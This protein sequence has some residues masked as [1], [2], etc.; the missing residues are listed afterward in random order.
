MGKWR[1][2]FPAHKS[3]TKWI[4][5][6]QLHAPSLLPPGKETPY[7][8]N[9]RLSGPRSLFW[10]LNQDPSGVLFVAE[11]LFQMGQ[12]SSR[13]HS[14]LSVYQEWGGTTF[15]ATQNISFSDRLECRN[16]FSLRITN[17]NFSSNFNIT[18][19]IKMF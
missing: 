6:V 18:F 10:E 4:W 14:V 12:S 9:R 16:D 19:Y 15:A 2:T 8:M 3:A 1:T 5:M 17:A 13:Q 11:W 7:P